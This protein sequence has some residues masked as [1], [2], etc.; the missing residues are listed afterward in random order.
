MRPGFSLEKAFWRNFTRAYW[1]RRPTVIRAPFATPIV[2]PREV[3]R[4]LLAARRRLR[5]GEPRDDLQ[6]TIAGRRIVLHLDRWL[7]RAKDSTVER[8]HAR[9]SLNGAA[10]DLSLLVYDFQQELGWA[11]QDRLRQFLHGLYEIVGVPPRAQAVLFLGNYRRTAF[12]LHRDESDVFCFVVDGKKRFRLWPGEAFRSSS[13]KFGPAPYGDYLKGSICL[14]GGP[15][16]ILFWPSSY[17]HVA[18]SDGR[19]GSSL[20]VG[21]SYGFSV[22]AALSE[23]IGDWSREMGGG[24]CDPISALPFSKLQAS[25]ELAS[26]AQRAEGPAGRLAE[27]LMRFWMERTTS[28]GFGRIPGKRARGTL[29]MGRRLRPN[30]HSPILQWKCNGELVIAANGR[31]LVV[32]YDREVVKMLGKVSRGPASD[33]TE[34]LNGA[35]GTS[36]RASR[37]SIRRTLKF[38][39]EEGALESA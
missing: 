17:W 16:D 5:L 37:Q 11:F 12:G 20:S 3:F 29:R 38:L 21:L 7:P 1:N 25:R 10:R 32:A 24:A 4:G 22:F 31:S 27:R 15:G 34:L 35:R 39:L 2:T 19:M 23:A 30:A 9:V 18:E 36:Q 8:Y 33:V 26:M 28:Y 14:E 13:E 6:L